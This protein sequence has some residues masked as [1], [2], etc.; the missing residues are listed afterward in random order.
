MRDYIIKWKA[1]EY[2]YVDR[3]PDWFWAFGIVSI[4]II[5][6]SIVLGNVLFALLVLVGSV[7]LFIFSIRHPQLQDYSIG[8]RGIAF[9]N[10][11]YPYSSLSSFWIET[12]GETP[13]LLI[14]SKKTIMPLIVLPLSEEVEFE[15]IRDYLLDHLDE[16]HLFESV[17]QKIME[18]LG[19]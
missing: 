6:T 7:A 11:V 4:S 19:F 13:K 9:E 18:R 10:K 12:E 2:D 5:L 3:K 8:Q 17:T 1:L 16:E 14:K 15:D